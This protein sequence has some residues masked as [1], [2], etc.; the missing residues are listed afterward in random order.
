MTQA[1][2]LVVERELLNN[3]NSRMAILHAYPARPIVLGETLCELPNSRTD[4]PLPYA[5]GL[6]L[7]GAASAFA[8][9]GRR[10]AERGRP[11]KGKD[12]KIELAW[13][14]LPAVLGGRHSGGDDNKRQR[15]QKPR[16]NNGSVH[17][18]PLYSTTGSLAGR[19]NISRTKLSDRESRAWSVG[20]IG[21]D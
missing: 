6:P 5:S 11:R 15:N 12:I 3:S 4:R 14:V 1:R 7:A 8:A 17:R 2:L 16:N 21:P 19:R 13:R 10:L 20:S 9:L 18:T